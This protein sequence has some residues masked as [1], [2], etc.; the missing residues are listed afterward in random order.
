[1]RIE[2]KRKIPTVNLFGDD[3]ISIFVRPTEYSEYKYAVCAP[4][5]PERI[6]RV[7]GH[8]M[9]AASVEDARSS[10]FRAWVELGCPLVGGAL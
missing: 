5:D 9:Y 4:D 1:M 10:I 2:T 8:Q 7:V 6:V 3:G